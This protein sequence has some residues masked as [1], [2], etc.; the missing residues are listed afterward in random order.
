M[1]SDLQKTATLIDGSSF[2]YRGYYAFSEFKSSNGDHLG[3]V[4]GFCSTLIS[5]INNHASDF[6]VI[7]FDAGRHT[8]RNDLYDQYKSHRKETPEDL[9]K[10]FPIVREACAAF[11]VP[12]VEKIGFEA[13]DIIATYATNLSQ[14]N[15]YKV[16]V[17]SIDKDLMQLVNDDISL[18]NP[19]KSK[20]INCCDVFDLYGVKPSQMTHMQAL[21]GD[22]ADN[23]PGVAGIGPKTAAKLIA[24]FGDID[25]IYNNIDAVSPE[26]VKSKLIS[27]KD[28][29]HLSL[30]LVT[31][32]KDVDIDIDCETSK[33][34]F[35]K[36]SAVAFLQKYELTHLLNKL[37]S[38]DL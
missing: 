18:F 5:L 25:G 11:G 34:K 10:Q 4:Y 37:S 36:R 20:E 32:K 8:F 21:M 27:Q 28:M 12:I 35:D 9:K 6:F 15:M 24:Q 17:V 23:I 19:T 16:R 33:I 30:K 22:S 38:I 7:V 1:D 14:N 3:A 29:L 13:D 26:K 31:L 2:V